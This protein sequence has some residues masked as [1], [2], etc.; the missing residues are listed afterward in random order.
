MVG[1]NCH[2]SALHYC[3]SGQQSVAFLQFSKVKFCIA[4]NSCEQN[5]ISYIY[6]MQEYST[7]F[8]HLSDF[9]GLQWYHYGYICFCGL[10]STNDIGISIYLGR[11]I[12]TDCISIEYFT[13]C[14]HISRHWV[15]FSAA[16]F[17]L[18][19]R[20]RFWS[21][22]SH[23]SGLRWID[24]GRWWNSFTAHGIRLPYFARPGQFSYGVW[25]LVCWNNHWK[26]SLK[27]KYIQF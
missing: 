11:K 14:G 4:E 22:V 10:C 2:N 15:I 6:W 3:H 26:G 8:S 19:K 9:V 1:W 27:I 7:H 12:K 21:T 23:W 17:R 24:I 25:R 13:Q 5:Y 18:H 20:Q 16:W